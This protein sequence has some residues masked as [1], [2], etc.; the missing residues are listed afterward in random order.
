MTAVTNETTHAGTTVSG[1]LATTA[2]RHWKT[3]IA[4]ALFALIAFVAFGIIGRAGTTTFRFS[5][6]DDVVQLP[7]ITVPTHLTGLILSIVLL[8]GAAY[9]V[10]QVVRFRTV[11]FWI[12]IV[13][14]FLFLVTFL[15]WASAS[16]D[17]SILVAGLLTGAVGL[18]VP[19]IFGALGGVISERVGVVNVAIEGQLL[20]GAF[21]SALVGSATHLPVLGLLAAMIA[22][23]LVSFVLAA[24][25]IKYLVDQ[26]I[27]GVVLNVLV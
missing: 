4:L 22:G 24:F 3:P 6:T 9:A 2:V 10:A 20:A 15:V 12:V 18:S 1:G 25:S 19:L 8:V 5:N 11:Q 16:P 23:M 13:F 21:V 7:A 26:V 14:A 27:V 17:R